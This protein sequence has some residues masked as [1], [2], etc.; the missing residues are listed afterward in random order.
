MLI[1]PSF[2]CC[3]ASCVL[4]HVNEWRASTSSSYGFYPATHTFIVSYRT[5][6]DTLA[7]DTRLEWIWNFIFF[8]FALVSLS[9][10]LY[11]YITTCPK[12]G[13]HEQKEPLK[14]LT[15]L[16]LHW[17]SLPERWRKVRT[18]RVCVCVCMPCWKLEDQLKKFSTLVENESHE[19]KRI[20]ESTWPVFRIHH[21]RS[22][23]IYDLYYKRKI[24]S[25]DLYD[26][27]LKNKYADANL[28]AKWKKVGLLHIS[29]RRSQA[30]HLLLTLQFFS[31]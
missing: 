26:Y 11:N 25:R 12:S 2:Q 9:L 15:R 20:V 21:Q 13:R 1:F 3:N 23:Y 31:F 5:L 17:K 29:S 30:Q 16:S 8:I 27:L 6:Q 28:I 7:R 10:Q 24:I 14:A 22:R 19:G 4:V 18:G